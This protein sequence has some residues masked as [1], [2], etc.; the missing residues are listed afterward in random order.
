MS[1]IETKQLAKQIV[2]GKVILF[3]GAGVSASVGMPTWRDMIDKMAEDLKFDPAEFSGF[4]DYLQLASFY[5]SK[6]GSIDPILNWLKIRAK[7]IQ[8][9]IHESRILENIARIGFRKIYTTN[10]DKILERSFYLHNA[11]HKTI[12]GIADLSDLSEG[13]QIIKFHGDFDRKSQI[14]ITETDYFDRF[15]FN[16][17][18]DIKFRSDSIGNSIL[19]IGYS[20]SDVNIRYLIYRLN[21]IWE[22]HKETKKL[23]SYIFLSECNP[24]K[25]VILNDY[26]IV[27]IFGQGKDFSKDLENFLDSLLKEVLNGSD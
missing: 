21:K 22:S 15:D 18:F 12:R 3:V 13:T 26:G 16:H 2:Q 14:V 25:Q 10:Y 20:F 8:P 17:P 7:E 1:S 9:A 19:F 27:P 23:K 11:K 6:I 24:V 4:G 5:K